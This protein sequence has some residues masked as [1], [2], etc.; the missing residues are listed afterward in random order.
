VRLRYRASRRVENLVFGLAVHRNDGAHVCGPNT[1]FAGLDIPFVEGE[2]HVVY[3]VDSLPLMEGTYLVS[4][5]VL[6]ETSTVTYDFHNRLYPFKVRQVGGGERYG[7]VSLMGKWK[8]VDADLGT[9]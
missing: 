1:K 9:R 2:G 3:H 7:L 4:L 5:A 6:N 8:W